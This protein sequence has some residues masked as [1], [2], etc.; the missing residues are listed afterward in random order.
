MNKKELEEVKID[1]SYK[2]SFS[3]DDT[4]LS[5][6]MKNKW[7]KS[8][9]GFILHYRLYVPE[10]YN[11]NYKYPLITFFHGAGEVG[12]DNKK[13]LQKRFVFLH[14]ILN[15][16]NLVANGETCSG[17]SLVRNDDEGILYSE[18]YIKCKSYTTEGYQGW[19]VE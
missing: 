5:V 8:S 3:S 15:K 11:K 19:R 9:N 13:Q 17:Y 16:E 6:L 18:S 2:P 10:N 7:F 12:K 14:R 4:D 1:L